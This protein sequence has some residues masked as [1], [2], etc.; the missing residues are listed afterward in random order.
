MA[1]ERHL[2]N[3]PITEAIIDVRAAL[4]DDYPVE[5]LA[6][7]RDLI[8][9]KYPILEEQRLFKATVE[10]QHGRVAPATADLGLN[11]YIF[12][13]SDRLT[14]A[15]FRRDGFT[16]NRLKPYTSW[17]VLL[18]EAR[19]L[20]RLYARIAG[21][22]AFTRVATRFINH[23]RVPALPVADFGRFLTDAPAPP[24]GAPGSTVGFLSRVEVR[25]QGTD[26][27][28]VVTQA[29]EKAVEPGLVTIILDIDVY[30]QGSFRLDDAA[31]DEAFQALH[32]TKNA[33]FFGAITEVTAGEY[34]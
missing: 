3:A 13:T 6:G 27:R 2:T 11:G 30:K 20:W 23:L 4:P 7:V 8:R 26:V 16:L 15:Q 12:R 24:R 25:D 29:T 14:V 18:P 9:E 17:N 5:R 19:E 28:A 22:E 21:V 33:V 31:L 10:F 32:T 1:R 34:E